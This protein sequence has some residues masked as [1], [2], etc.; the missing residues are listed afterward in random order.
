MPEREFK[1]NKKR[2]D[3]SINQGMIEFTE[4]FGSAIKIP[5]ND[6]VLSFLDYVVHPDDEQYLVYIHDDRKD[7][8]NNLACQLK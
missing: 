6:T 7:I 3:V 4:N 8:E 1:R 5:I 2:L